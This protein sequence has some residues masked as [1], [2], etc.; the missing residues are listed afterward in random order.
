MTVEKSGERETRGVFNS[1]S[2]GRN[3]PPSPVSPP[4]F[5]PFFYSELLFRTM[6]EIYGSSKFELEAIESKAHW[7]GERIN[8]RNILVI[9]L[10]FRW[11]LFES[12]ELDI[13]FSLRASFFERKRIYITK[14]FLAKGGRSIVP[15]GVDKP[16]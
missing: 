1:D 11:M 15:F 8:P 9:E 5:L 10:H 16:I 14:P 12:I 2:L 13:L 7:I 3:G 6:H 4:F